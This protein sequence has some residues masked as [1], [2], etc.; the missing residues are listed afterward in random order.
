M[1]GPNLDG[2]GGISRIV[3]IWKESGIFEEH[4]VSYVSTAAEEPANKTVFLLWNFFVFIRLLLRRK[5][6]VYIHTSSFRSFYRKSLFILTALAAGKP[7]ILHI[8]PSHFY[9]FLLGLGRIGGYYARFL[10]SRI[11]GFVVLSDDMKEKMGTQFPDTPVL[12]LRN[13]VDLRGMRN[14]NGYVR[15]ENLI[16]FLGWFIKAKGI[17]ELVDAFELLLNRG[18][19]LQLN[20]YGT[21][22]SDRL[23]DYVSKKGL[24]KAVKVNGW[25]GPQEKV[26]VLYE[27]TMLV[28]PSHSEGVPNVILEAMATRTPI[29]ATRVGGLREILRDSENAVIAEVNDPV[30]LSDK[31]ARLL[32]DPMFREKIAENAYR[33]VVQKYD[34]RV[35]K[36][37]FTRI[38]N[39]II[40]LKPSLIKE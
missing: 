36:R 5:V 32:E 29:V 21:K 38:L 17:Y 1:I 34:I 2:L 10:L 13:P 4:K 6:I 7:V 40:G 37:D 33:E 20:F 25:I 31:M 14:N 15:Q 9:D 11:A 39:M 30:D 28:L 18:Y 8:H 12:V 27:S 23:R 24:T 3:R 26:R 16:L 22:E 19:L 35:V